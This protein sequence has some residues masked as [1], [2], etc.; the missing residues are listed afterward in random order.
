M[1]DIGAEINEKLA[2]IVREYFDDLRK[3]Q[4]AGKIRVDPDVFRSM[5]HASKNLSRMGE[6]GTLGTKYTAEQAERSGDVRENIRYRA[7]LREKKAMQFPNIAAMMTGGA[8][9]PIGLMG[10]MQKQMSKPFKGVYDYK[11]AQEASK[12]FE[13]EMQEKFDEDPFYKMS[14]AEKKRGRRLSGEEEGTKQR[15]GGGFGKNLMGKR[16]QGMIGKVGKFME[17]SKGQGMMAGGMMGASILTMIIKKAMEASP[18]LQQML[19]IMNVAM[20]LFLRPIGDFIGGMLKPIMLFFL[21]EIAVPMLKRGKDFIKFG[22]QFG[23][24][25]LG[26][27]LK[28]VETISAAIVGSLGIIVGPEMAKLAQNFDG[29]K[30]WMT[31]QKMNVLASEMGFSP[32]KIGRQGLIDM[33]NDARFAKGNKIKGGPG[34]STP[35]ESQFDA[36]GYAELEAAFGTGFIATLQDT[37]APLTLF[38]QLMTDLSKNTYTYV[39]TQMELEGAGLEVAK[40]MGAISGEFAGISEATGTLVKTFNELNTAMGATVSWHTSQTGELQELIN[41]SKLANPE[42][43]EKALGGPLTEI[44]PT[45]D[46]VITPTG[47]SDVVIEEPAGPQVKK[48]QSGIPWRKATESLG[49]MAASAAQQIK[50]GLLEGADTTAYK[51]AIIDYKEL[52]AGGN[53]T[54]LEGVQAKFKILGETSHVAMINAGLMETNTDTML[55]ST[56]K[57]TDNLETGAV[58]T[59]DMLKKIQSQ[60]ANMGN[61]RFGSGGRGV[62]LG[63]GWHTQQTGELQGLIN[64]SKMNFGS[65]WA[66]ALGRQHGGMINEPIWGIGK[67]GQKYKFGE[68]GPEM[69]TPMTRSGAGGGIGPVTINV[70]VDSINSDVDLEKIKPVIERALQEVHSRRG[71]I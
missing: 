54:M 49:A 15:A 35:G 37:V 25:I 70:N 71:I 63:T 65:D 50:A 5:Q 22:E 45:G 6:E 17:S 51:Q 24:N 2:D 28:P 27:L 3:Q 9:G 56:Q 55:T 44:S 21:R 8:P 23:K 53:R 26:F 1:A 67:S 29:M 62:N 48:G 7:S 4:R 10:S 59:G 32:D 20:T 57:M 58:V 52:T 38:K 47:G 12:G 40:G 16:M 36:Q 39:T 43:W 13:G 46:V 33:V 30:E 68:A 19:K 14:K 18:M 34:K 42:A 66:T 60:S 11:K 41:E 61:M 64:Q 31:E 69:I